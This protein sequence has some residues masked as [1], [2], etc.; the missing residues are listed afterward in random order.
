[1]LNKQKD[2]LRRYPKL[3]IER[4]KKIDWM[5]ILFLGG[6]T[7]SITLC[8]IAN[9]QITKN[10]FFVVG[11]IASYVLVVI[12]SEEAKKEYAKESGGEG[13]KKK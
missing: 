9:F 11:I 13:K 6:F 12:V 1:M 4:F 5:L 2:E 7:F 3:I 10:I 8:F